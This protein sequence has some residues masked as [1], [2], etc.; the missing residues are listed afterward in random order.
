MNGNFNYENLLV[1]G[2]GGG[3]EKELEAGTSDTRTLS[4]P[5]ATAICA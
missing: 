5:E 1:G 4:K 3:K 2:G